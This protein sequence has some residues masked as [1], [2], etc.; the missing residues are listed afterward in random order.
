M[1]AIYDIAAFPSTAASVD[2][3]FEVFLPRSFGSGLMSG[4]DSLGLGSLNQKFF[5][6]ERQAFRQGLV[7][8]IASCPASDDR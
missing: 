8:S 3:S 1:S 2:D 7:M 6:G 5:Y 4:F